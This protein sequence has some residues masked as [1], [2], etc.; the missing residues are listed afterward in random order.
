MRLTGLLSLIREDARYQG[1]LAQARTGASMGSLELLEAARPYLVAALRDD[2]PG[3]I[4]LVSGR[5]EQAHQLYDE[6]RAWTTA[7]E[8]VIQFPAPDT[9]FY[10]RSPWDR[11]TVQG[12]VAALAALAE[13]DSASTG[14]GLLVHAS[15]WALMAKSVPPAAFRR[16]TRTLRVGDVLPMLKLLEECVRAGYDPAVVVE[17]P[18]TFAHRGSIIDIYPPNLPRPVRIDLFG[19][20]IDSLRLFDPGSQ[21]S[22]ER[23]DAVTLAPASE[24]LPAWG[25]AAGP[26]LERLDLSGCASAVR[27]RMEEERERLLKGVFFDGLEF[28]LPYLYPRPASLLDYLPDN[29]LVLVDDLLALETAALGLE[30]QALSLRGELIEDGQLPAGL[31]VPYWGWEELK[32]RL[33]ARGA[34]SLGYGE[35]SGGAGNGGAFFREALIAAPRYGGQL[36]QALADIAELRDDGQRIVIVTRQAERLSDL[37]R[38]QDIYAEPADEIVALPAPGAVH[39]VDGILAQGWA[40]PECGLVLLTDAEVFGWMRMRRRPARRRRGAPENLFADLADDDYVVHVDYGIGR[41]HGMVRKTVNGVEREYLEIE[42]A[43]GDRLFVPIHQADRVSC[44]LGAEEREPYLHRLGG[45][46]W[47]TVRAKAEKAVRDIAAELLELYAAR[48]VT[49][50]HAFS[51]DTEWQRELEGSFAYEETGDQLRALAEIKADMERP[52]PMDRLICGDVGYG[53]TEVALR[54]AFKAVMDGK[55]VAVLVPTTVLAEQHYR[56][57]SGR[58]SPYPMTVEVLS[59]FRTPREQKAV[60]E[61]AASGRVDVVIGTHRLLQKD[62]I[63]KSLGLVIVDEEHR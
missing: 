37:L 16:A 6:T 17:Q 2:W 10:D 62:V 59:R 52:K 39:V 11:E 31:A 36:R 45:P 47:I 25:K 40:Y 12:R 8:R 5:P 20:E 55:Q 57:F 56:T 21:R 42:Y 9:V 43:S 22:E 4:M 35:E 26:A 28:Y 15:I 58:L 18:G 14:Q 13:L 30:N 63:F 7:P 48:E 23:L 53:K 51:P 41:Y 46:E 50:G 27:Q 3:P 24:A 32:A 33:A 44:Y 29:A 19:D 1:L 60:L 34:V 54:A 61:R 38:E 49:L